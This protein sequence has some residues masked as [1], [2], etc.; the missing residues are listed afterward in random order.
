MVFSSLIFWFHRFIQTN[1]QN[2]SEHQDH[3]PDRIS[4]SLSLIHIFYDSPLTLASEYK[5]KY[6]RLRSASRKE[7]EICSSSTVSPLVPRRYLNVIKIF[8]EFLKKIGWHFPLNHVYFKYSNCYY[9]CFKGGFPMANLKYS[10]QRESIK[11]FLATTKEHP[12][13]DTV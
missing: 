13:A 10:R 12:T 3:N 4:P 2:H 11:H 8:T 9:Y 5:G 1:T 7:T 6:P